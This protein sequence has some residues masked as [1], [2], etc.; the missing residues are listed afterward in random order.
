MKEEEE[1]EEEQQQAEEDEFGK[2]RTYIYTVYFKREK[3]TT[4]NR[5]RRAITTTLHQDQD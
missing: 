4:D 3:Q 1:E 5:F 2:V